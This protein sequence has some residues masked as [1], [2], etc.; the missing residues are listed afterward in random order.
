MAPSW[1]LLLPLFP[2]S[3]P[4]AAGGCQAPGA[5]TL[6]EE[7]APCGCRETEQE[8]PSAPLDPA[9]TPADILLPRIPLAPQS[10]LCSTLG[11]GRGQSLS[12]LQAPVAL[13]LYHQLLVLNY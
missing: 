6:Q 12:A 11:W 5:G 10:T 7:G 9:R 4:P 3:A 8:A 2:G 1:V 13:L